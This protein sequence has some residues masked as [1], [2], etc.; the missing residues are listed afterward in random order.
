MNII[1]LSKLNHN[2]LTSAIKKMD[3]EEVEALLILIDKLI[4]RRFELETY[5][6]N[7]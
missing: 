6:L 3:E 5:L 1:E 7:M 2:Q 4:D